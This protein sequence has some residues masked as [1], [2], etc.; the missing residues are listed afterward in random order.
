MA[1]CIWT[2]GTL[3]KN[4]N[5]LAISLIAKSN[6]WKAW[7]P[8]INGKE[9]REREMSLGW[10]KENWKLKPPHSHWWSDTPNSYFYWTKIT[11]QKQKSDRDILKKDSN[12]WF[13][14]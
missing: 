9:M 3:K 12:L 4:L 1:A 11:S 10:N 13:I 8:T 6:L 2:H 14:Y 5:C 7:K